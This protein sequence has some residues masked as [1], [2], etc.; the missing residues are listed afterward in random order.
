M[1][2][3]SEVSSKDS[4][5]MRGKGNGNKAIFYL[6]VSVCMSVTNINQFSHIN[7]FLRH[8]VAPSF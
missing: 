3:D 1:M 7:Q 2:I 6:G 4:A 8:P 5:A